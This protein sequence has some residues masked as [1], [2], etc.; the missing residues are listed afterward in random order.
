[1]FG[2]DYENEVV[3]FYVFLIGNNV[4]K[5]GFVINFLLSYFGI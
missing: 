4:F 5:V 3:E 1:M 2:L